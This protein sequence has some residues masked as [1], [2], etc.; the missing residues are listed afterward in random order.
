MPRAK[1]DGGEIEEVER[2]HPAWLTK[3]DGVGKLKC[4]IRIFSYHC[5]RFLM[6]GMGGKRTCGRT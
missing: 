1:G 2:V 4:L 3:W 5:A 6:A